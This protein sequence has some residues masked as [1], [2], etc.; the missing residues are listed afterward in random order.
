[1]IY[2]VSIK[3]TDTG[4]HVPDGTEITVRG[5]TVKEA[6]ERLQELIDWLPDHM[7]VVLTNAT[8]LWV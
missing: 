6:D 5:A 7:R 2:K 1:M 3:Y 4:D 8:S